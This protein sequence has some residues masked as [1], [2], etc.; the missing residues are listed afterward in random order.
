MQKEHLSHINPNYL[1]GCYPLDLSDY[2]GETNFSLIFKKPQ[3]P[4]HPIPT[5][6]AL[7]NRILSNIDTSDFAGKDYFVRYMH[8]K[9]R[10][11]CQPNTLQQA[12]TS[13]TQFLSFYRDRGKQHLQHMSREDLEAFVEHQHPICVDDCTQPVSDHK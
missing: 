7:L 2:F 8:H 3:T 9:Y 11:N 10:R 5:R 4:T 6:L 13:L 12:A 1:H